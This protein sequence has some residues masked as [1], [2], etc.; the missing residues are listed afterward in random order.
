MMP[1]NSEFMNL[2]IF[3]CLCAYFLSWLLSA[4][5]MYIFTFLLVD[6]TFF[7]LLQI[8]ML[9]VCMYLAIYIEPFKNFTRKLIMDIE[10]FEIDAT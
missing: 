3:Y 7:Q 6:N 1:Q 9:Y 4:G 10:Q 8:K 5:G 2:Y